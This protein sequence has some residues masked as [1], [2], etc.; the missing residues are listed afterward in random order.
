MYCLLYL[1]ANACPDTEMIASTTPGV[2][3]ALGLRWMVRTSHSH[4]KFRFGHNKA[5]RTISTKCRDVD[6]AMRHCGVGGSERSNVGQNDVNVI[7]SSAWR[8]H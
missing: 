8:R 2:E 6:H 1:L 7:T 3:P 5:K 4:L